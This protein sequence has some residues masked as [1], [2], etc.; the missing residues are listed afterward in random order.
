M[1]L[2]ALKT[3]VTPCAAMTSVGRT[4]GLALP[5]Q[6]WKCVKRRGG[7]G[8]GRLTPPSGF[9]WMSKKNSPSPFHLDM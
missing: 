9:W 8:P 3:F 6:V 7:I 1:V 2:L 4:E 5:L